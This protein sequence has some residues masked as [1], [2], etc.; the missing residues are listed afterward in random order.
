MADKCLF[1]RDLSLFKRQWNHVCTN[2]QRRPLLWILVSNDASLTPLGAFTSEGQVGL[3]SSPCGTPCSSSAP[4]RQEFLPSW[5]HE[6]R[7]QLPHK[8]LLPPAQS[9]L[10][11]RTPNINISSLLL[12]LEKNLATHHTPW[13]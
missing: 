5:P 9:F 4:L 1:R 10:H 6:S 3:H 11:R 8:I 13:C 12:G 2:A 7:L